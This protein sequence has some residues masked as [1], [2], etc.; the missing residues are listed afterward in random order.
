MF[1]CL[2]KYIQLLFDPFQLL[3]TIKTNEKYLSYW[4]IKLLSIKKQFD[5]IAHS[6]EYYKLC[7]DNYL[8]LLDFDDFEYRQFLK[9]IPTYQ[10][11]LFLY[12]LKQII[13]F[14]SC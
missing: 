5:H 7:N 13:L 14:S 2:P 6:I 3:G 4:E 8:E 9:V 11:S 10:F 1:L 12:H